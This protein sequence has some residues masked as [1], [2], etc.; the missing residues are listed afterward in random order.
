MTKTARRE[1]ASQR[2]STGGFHA[3]APASMVLRRKIL[4]QYTTPG[5]QVANSGTSTSS[6]IRPICSSTNG[7]T[8]R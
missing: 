8:P 7:M 5:N 1:L 4:T 3:N 2:K 6:A